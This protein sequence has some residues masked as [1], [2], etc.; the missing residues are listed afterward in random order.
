M[1]FNLAHTA[2]YA[3]KPYLCSRKFKGCPLFWAG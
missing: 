3:E 1:F 2:R